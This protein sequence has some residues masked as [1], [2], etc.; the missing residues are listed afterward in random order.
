MLGQ[1]MHRPLRI[2]DI[3]TFAEELHGDAGIV[4]STVEGGRHWQSYRETG[5][6]ARRLAKALARL[7][8]GAGDRVAT[9]AWNGYRHMELYYGVPGIGAVCHTLNPR[10]S[11]EQA[12]YIVGHAEDRALFLD[13]TFVPLVEKLA[14]HFP[15]EMTY[16]IMTDRAHMPET[17]LPGALCYEELLA[18]EDDGFDWPDLAEE[19]AAGL[20][21]TSGTTG[22][23]KGSL[24][25]HRSMVLHAFT[26]CI[27][28]QDAMRAGRRLLPVVPLFHANA[29]GMAHAGPLAGATLVMPGPHLDGASVFELMQ[30]ERVFSAW[31]V[32]TVWLGL[33][34]EIARRDRLP[35]G[36]GEVVIGGSAAAPSLIR[37]FEERGVDVV[38][39]W[40]MTEMSPIGTTTKLGPAAAEVPLEERLRLK[41]FQGRRAFGVD[42]K[43]VGED[44]T[45]QPHDGQAVGELFVRGNTVVS[46]Y[47]RNEDASAAA[48]DAEGW[49][50]T[51]DVAAIT[52]EG[53]LNITDRTK[54]LIKSGGEWISSIDVENMA[55]AHPDI[56]NAA[57][58]AVPH[59]RW[60]ERPVLIAVPAEGRVPDTADLLRH[61][62]EH[63]AKWQLPDDV[64][65]VDDLP[66]T[67]TGKVSK[68]TLRQM[69]GDH[70]LPGT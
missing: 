30:A 27:V 55:I 14:A 24:F 13:L 44:G 53:F 34:D 51:G 15:A 59:P 16:V 33:M 29:W 10:L 20:C 7:G 63:L 4:S 41:S 50:G 9:L 57:V 19:T 18:A 64:I 61:L 39:A 2:A 38:H 43:I 28:M 21:Y 37:A 65:Y 62:G 40:G 66:L 52:P 68:L 54:D 22:N 25:T 67:A 47:F 6:R 45:R 70:K 3:L 56:A 17:S 49:F 26:V 60:G 46:G 58:I 8:I 11:A 12:V 1:M 69:Y 32:P 31:G 5:A 42:L 23:P 48:I 35:E 36:F